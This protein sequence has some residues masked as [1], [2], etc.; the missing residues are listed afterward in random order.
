MEVFSDMLAQTFLNILAA[1][2]GFISASF[3][4]VGV[5]RMKIEDM[6][7][8]ATILWDTNQHL[9]DSIASQRA[10][11][12]TGALLLVLSFSLQLA[13]NLVPP[14]LEPSL[15]QPAGCAAAGIV[16]LISGL[17]LASV[18]LRNAVAKST[19]ASVHALLESEARQEGR[20]NRKQ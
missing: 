4:S 20:P 6:A 5:L 2:V 1:C 16:A 11:Y 15:L 9:A 17:L 19:K 13:A 7:Y 8:S 10:D 3:F 14:A 12:I 18:L